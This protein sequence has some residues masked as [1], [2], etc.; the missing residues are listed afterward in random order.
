[1]KF[2]AHRGYKTKNIQEN[3]MIAFENAY[4]DDYFAGFELDVRETKDKEFVILHDPIINRVSNGSGF[5]SNFKYQELLKYN[6]GTITYPSKLLKLKN[7]LNRFSDK[8]IVV[9]LKNI[10]SIKKLTRLLNNYTNIYVASFNAVLLKKIIKLKP[11]FK[12]GLFNNILNSEISY[13]EY[14]FVGIY[15]KLALDKN[16]IR[17]FYTR[18][19]EVIAFGF[20]NDL[21]IEKIIEKIKE[22]I[23]L[24]IDKKI[25]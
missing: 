9:E 3:T 6:F 22:E 25:S 16:I 2:I 15:Q 21:N 24:I 4:K 13:K 20:T 12:I 17:Y 11:K 19:I 8:K 5:V 10:K 23:F 1:M 14:D 18:K 7:V